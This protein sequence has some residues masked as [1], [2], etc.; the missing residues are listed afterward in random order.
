M[1]MIDAAHHA[2]KDASPLDYHTYG[3]RLH[4]LIFD[5][6]INFWANLAISAGFTYW[7]KH[8]A[9]PIWNG[10]AG[11]ASE[12]PAQTALKAVQYGGYGI[13][14]IMALDGI[15][16]GATSTGEK[17]SLDDR[18]SE[19]FSG[20]AIAGLGHLA[21]NS[22]N[23]VRTFLSQ[24]PS[25]AQDWL[26]NKIH[27]WR[28]MNVFD[29]AH[30]QEVAKV[31]ADGMT[32][33]SAGTFIMIPGVWGGAKIK[34]DFVRWADRR[35]YGENAE[36]IPWVAEAHE[37]IDHERKPTLVGYGVGRLGSMGAVYLAGY[38]LGH[39]TS[40]VVTWAGN[41]FSIS[42]L[43]KFRGIDEYSGIIGDAM[44]SGAAQVAPE[45]SKRINQRL[46]QKGFWLSENQF[47]QL[48]PHQKTGM[49]FNAISRI[50]LADREKL[51]H[52]AFQDYGKYVGMDTLYTMVTAGTVK[53][54]IN[55]ARRIIPGLAYAPQTAQK[56]TPEPRVSQITRE[57]TVAGDIAAQRQA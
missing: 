6:G 21:G 4:R 20:A 1:P 41:K 31:I 57:H 42:A 44:G 17:R 16:R 11:F 10:A 49:D 52:S 43:K 3:E 25:K 22:T 30:R 38:A 18:A 35:H 26:R 51:Y 27:D 53:P 46:T 54:V 36:D 24:R 5:Q 56:E 8:S 33:T 19:V 13:G 28:G 40:N 50:P 37:R 7:V 9:K 47:E 12:K 14:A 29:P 23:F 34:G 2:K 55:L 15:F 48:V 45:L 39:N 32:L